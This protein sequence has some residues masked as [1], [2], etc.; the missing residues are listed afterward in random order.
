MLTRAVVRLVLSLDFL[1]GSLALLSDGRSEGEKLIHIQC[2][3]RANFKMAK[4]IYGG[5]MTWLGFQR[6]FR[7]SHPSLN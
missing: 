5:R 6:H 2:M 1:A 3:V 4:Q 7:F